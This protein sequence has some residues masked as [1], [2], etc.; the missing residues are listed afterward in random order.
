[1]MII[2]FMVFWPLGMAVLAYILWGDRL[3][4]FKSEVSR[5][6][7]NVVDGL[8]TF[9]RNSGVYQSTARTGNAAFDEWRDGEIAR[10]EEKRREL[11]E[12]RREFDEHLRELRKARD[13]EEFNS[14]MQSKKDTS[15][16]VEK[17][18]NNKTVPKIK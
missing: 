17:P 5:A 13:K 12:T 15:T 10:L 9:G 11:D 6:T 16:K 1:M 7:D 4:S 3:D 14:F 2:G 8:N 18:K